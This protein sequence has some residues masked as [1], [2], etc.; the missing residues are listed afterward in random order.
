[1]SETYYKGLPSQPP[2]IATTKPGPFE[3]PTGPEA[4][5]ILKELRCLGNHPLAAIWDNGL[6][7]KLGASLTSMGVNWTCLDAVRI[8]NVGERPGPAIVWIGVEFGALSFEEGSKVAIKCHALTGSYGISDYCVE[9][10]ESHI[11]RQAGNRFFSP[12]HFSDPIFSAVDP[13]TAT[14]GIPIST[15]NAPWAEGT[16]G[17]YLSAGGGDK[18]I[19][20][21]TARHVVCAWN[22][23]DNREY[24]RENSSK[25]REDVIV[26]GTRGFNKKLAAIEYEIKGQLSIITDS[27]G[28]MESVQGLDDPKSVTEYKKAENDLEEA[29]NGVEA[30]RTLF[31]EI[32]IHWGGKENRVFGELIWAPPITYSTEPGQYTLDL[33]IIKIDTAIL[34]AGNYLGNMINIGKKYSRQEFMDRVYLHHASTT[35][36]KFPPSRLVKLIGEVPE[37]DLVKPPMLDA[38]SDPCLVVFKNGAMTGT[39]IGKANNVSSYTRSNFSGQYMESRE[40]PVI[41]TDKYSSPFSRAGDSGSCVADAYSRVGGIITGGSGATDSTDV[42][43]VTPISFIMKTLHDTKLFKQAHL[44]PGLT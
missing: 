13:Y 33:A 29:E 10:R 21:V 9:I 25:P 7:R 4:Y 39:T 42:T 2:L 27:K 19:Y 14:L 36:F 34:D 35:A 12:V 30:L 24:S 26:L 15:R 28:R 22:Q 16:G 32:G 3:E 6:A 18:N 43:Y 1:M 38:N 40:W 11:V 5:S 44:T 8:P 20:L 37:S 41:A 23:N 17:F 31:K